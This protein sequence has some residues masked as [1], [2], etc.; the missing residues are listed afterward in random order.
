MPVPIGTLGRRS[1]HQGNALP[2]LTLKPQRPSVSPQHR[3]ALAGR[4]GWVPWA[5]RLTKPL[6]HPAPSRGGRRGDRVPI[7]PGSPSIFHPTPGAFQQPSV[8]RVVGVLG[9]DV[10]GALRALRQPGG[11]RHRH[12]GEEAIKASL[13]LARSKTTW[14][15]RSPLGTRFA[16]GKG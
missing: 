3:R 10:F 11:R 5:V 6:R 16:G 4:V 7:P 15:T 2:I 14:T 13:H 12:P 9:A 1:R 8:F